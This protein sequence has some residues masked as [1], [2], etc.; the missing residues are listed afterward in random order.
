LKLI[1]TNDD[2]IDAPGLEALADILREIATPIIVAPDQPQ[3]TMSHRVT[4]RTPI[5]VNEVGKNR[6][7][8]NGTPADCARI[9]IKEIAS[10]V[11]W[12]VA[13]INPGANL[14]SDVYQSG[15]VAAAR[16]AAI[17]GCRAIAVSQ[18]IAKD[19]Q[20]DWGITKQHTEPVIKMILKQ[21]LIPGC[22]WNINIPHP[23]SENSNVDFEYCGLDTNP[24]KYIY[25]KEGSEYIYEGSIHERP[26]DPG[27]D[28]D[29]CFS[30][31][32]SITRLALQTA[33]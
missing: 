28:V 33:A 3:S 23:L 10:D 14:G 18:Y 22:F 1:L 27:K 30:G 24:H 21:D 15:T 26:R 29:V 32:I 8:V 17:L 19:C 20:V 11:S 2:G 25:R 12:L 9:A 6:F 31:N 16:E 7:S 5:R 4:T 13:G